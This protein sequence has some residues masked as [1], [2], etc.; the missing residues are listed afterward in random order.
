L[1]RKKNDTDA[2]PGDQ[3]WPGAF[4]ITGEH[5][6]GKTTAALSCGVPPKDIAFFDSDVKGISTAQEL[7]EAG[8]PLGM[9][10]NLTELSKG[11]TQYEL[12]IEIMKHLSDIK[13]NQFKA[14]IFDTWT[15]ISNTMHSYVMR[16]PKEFRAPEEWAKLGSIKGAQQWQSTRVLEAQIIN[17]LLMKVPTVILVTHLKDFYLNQV[18]VPGKQVPACSS[19][20]SGVCRARFWLRKSTD[21]NPVPT[22]LVFKQMDKKVFVPGRGIITT[23]VLPQRMEPQQGENS[24]W[25][26]VRRYW[27]DPLDTRDLLPEEKPSAYELSIISNALSEDQKKMLEALLSSG[28]AGEVEEELDEDDVIRVSELKNKGKPA[29]LIAKETGIPLRRVKGILESL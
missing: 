23:A 8:T 13:V 20:L 15:D 9:Y 25:D 24:V 29:P 4:H 17:E 18:K 28:L 21:G 11:R 26:M 1:P 14:I 12:H 27:N 2:A 19:V 16:N 7:E 5:N 6:V 22:V 10:V 3:V